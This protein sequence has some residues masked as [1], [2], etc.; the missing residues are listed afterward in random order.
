MIVRL[1]QKD[2]SDLIDRQYNE[3]LDELEIDDQHPVAEMLRDHLDELY[4]N[5]LFR[6]EEVASEY[7][8]PESVL[9]TEAEIEAAREERMKEIQAQRE[10]QREKQDGD[11]D[12][13]PE[14]IKLSAKEAKAVVFGEKRSEW[15]KN[16]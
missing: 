2:V 15:G 14:P 3:L 5:I 12:A 1:D 9:Q 4:S 11:S 7:S 10:A 13:Q 16:L 6:H 8:I